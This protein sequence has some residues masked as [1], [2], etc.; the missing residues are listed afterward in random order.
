VE[1]LLEDRR[2]VAEAQV[3][4]GVVEVARQLARLIED[5]DPVLQRAED[6][7][8]QRRREDDD[9]RDC[10]QPSSRV[11]RERC[12]STG[13]AGDPKSARLTIA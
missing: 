4:E 11:G 10:Q 2:R 5:G 3:Q 6:D 9:D 1:R 7:E 13:Q 12:P 8:G